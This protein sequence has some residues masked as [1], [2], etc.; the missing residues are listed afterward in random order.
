MSMAAV[1]NSS[2][3]RTPRAAV[4]AASPFA[5]PA[6]RGE[7]LLLQVG[8]GTGHESAA[9][10]VA[11]QGHGLGCPHQQVG[12]EPSGGQD[13]GEVL[14]GGALVPQQPQ[15]PGGLAERV[16]DL[17]EVEQPRVGVGGV[18]EPAQQ[19][20]QQGALD[21]GLAGD[22]GGQRLQVA[23]RGGRV[24]V[25]EGHQP[26]PRRSRAQPGL[27]GRELGDGVEQRTVEELLVEA[28]HHTGVPFPLAVQ[29]GDGIGPEPE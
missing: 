8:A 26:L 3:R 9:G 6:H 29:R 16:R 28:A 1:R 23:Q 2:R 13:P 17:A 11:E 24:R 19:D 25:P 15:I 18:G 21:G 4:T 12:G 22:A 20:G 10:A 27:T 7:D 14:G 5:G